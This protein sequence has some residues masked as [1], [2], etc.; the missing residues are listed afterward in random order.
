M[1]A[2]V[3]LEDY[4]GLIISEA[5]KVW[6]QLPKQTRAW[7][8][9]DDLIADGYYY[10]WRK[11][12][13]VEGGKHKLWDVNGKAKFST[14]LRWSLPRDYDNDITAKL[15]YAKQRNEKDTVG[16][17]ALKRPDWLT[18]GEYDWESYM[19]DKPGTPVL[20]CC[21]ADRILMLYDTA[22]PQ[23]KTQMI[24]WFLE[25]DKT[26]IRS[27][28]IKFER[29]KKEF[30]QLCDKY[31]VTY[32]DCY[33]LMWSPYCL[34]RFSRKA[35]WIPYNINDPTPGIGVELYTLPSELQPKP[36][37]KAKEDGRAWY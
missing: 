8:G 30:R 25:A 20:E 36:G 27:K 2:A 24:A 26:K 4:R 11:L 1:A 23:L 29:F 22:S 15:F 31:S 13:D 37:K 14:Y 32:D 34:D 18:G 7:L 33:H 9:L 28:G 21:I 17:E 3:L 35:R 19:L 12:H 5:L 6:R 16:I 10:A